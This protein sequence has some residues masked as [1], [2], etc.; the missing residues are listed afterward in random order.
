[1]ARDMISGTFKRLTFRFQGGSGGF[2]KERNEKT[3]NA[4]EAKIVAANV[5]SAG[6]KTKKRTK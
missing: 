4:V 3:A 2:P 6:S 1:M 5:T